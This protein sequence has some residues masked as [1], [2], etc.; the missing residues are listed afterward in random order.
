MKIKIWIQTRVFLQLRG[1][2]MQEK[3]PYALKQRRV[4][5]ALGAVLLGS[6]SLIANAAAV[7]GGTLDPTSIPK[8][9]T[10]L[11]IPP[12]MPQNSS[13]GYDIAV[14][15]FQQQ[16]LPAGFPSTTVWSYGREEDEVPSLAPSASSTF[17]YPAFTI[18]AIKDERITIN[19][20]NDLV[21]DEGN[22]LPHLVPI[23]QTLHWAN[24][25]QDCRMGAPRTDCRGSSQDLYTGP[26]PIVTHVHGAHTTPESDGYPEA[27]YLPVANDLP[28]GIS[29]EGSLYS[30][31]NGGAPG[32]GSALYEYTNDQPSAT[33]WYHDHSLG[34][35]RANVYAG[36]AGFYLIRE[37]D[38]GETYLKRGTLPGPAPALDNSGNPEDVN[39]LTH[40]SVRG[41]IREIPIVIQGRSFNEDGSLFYPDNRAFFEGVDVEQLQVPFIGD[42]NGAEVD[43]SPT[44]NPEAFFNTMVVNGG[45]WPKLHVAPALYRFRLLNGTNSRFLNLALFEV[46]REGNHIR[47][48]PFFQIGSDQS[49]LQHPVKIRTGF[50]TIAKKLKHPLRENDRKEKRADHPTEALLMGPAE[51]MDVIVDFRGMSSNTYIRMVNTAPDAPFGGF[52]DV[53]ADYETTGQIM[54]FEVKSKL[55]GMS[56]TDPAGATPA[57]SPWKLKV[58]NKPKI[59]KAK[60]KHVTKRRLALLEE[61]STDICATEDPA[62][63]ILR[64][65]GISVG[66][67]FAADCEAAG[68]FPFGP[69]AAVLGNISKNGEASVQLWSDP[70][71]QQPGLNSIEDWELWNLSADAHPIHLH[72]VKFW[73]TERRVIGGKKEKPELNERG[74]KDTVV[75]YPGEITKVRAK[76][77]IPGLYVWHC[78]ILEH[79]DNEMMVPFCV[80]SDGDSTRADGKDI[81]GN[82]PLM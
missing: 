48:I 19:W 70:I 52:P 75:V 82:L 14:R 9:V 25:M 17:N 58:K 35:T 51:R 37:A 6:A 73:V 32:T 49:L 36:P 18:E 22:Y 2:V 12:V 27:W 47:E 81:C 7:P 56:P 53:P 78:H 39:G 8:Y 30:D 54:V 57:T 79:E 28:A 38:G 62:G 23:D 44:W 34:M 33:L 45:T 59:L 13:G 69:K 68:G 29:T 21:D 74:W 50:K 3:I 1:N 26:V 61:E 16:I 76:F 67:G 10:P 77:D 24:P 71:H 15:Q 41:K 60:K 4:H 64:L 5:V 72:L 65:E 63:N 46:D 42:A 43:I 55:N 40:H 80:D 11:V 31:S 66:A 20:I